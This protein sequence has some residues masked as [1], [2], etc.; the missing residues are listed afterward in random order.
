MTVAKA[1]RHLF[2][3]IWWFLGSFGAPSACLRVEWASVCVRVEVQHVADDLQIYWATDKY[4]E[5]AEA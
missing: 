2:E 4:G 5:E 1:T 3:A